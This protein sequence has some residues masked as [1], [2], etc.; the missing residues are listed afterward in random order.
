MA[1]LAFCGLGR[2]G[3]PMASRLVAAGHDLVVWNRSP[4]RAAELVEA[5]AR[6]AASPAEA[7]SSADAVMTMLTTPEVVESVTVGGGDSLA[8]GLRPGATLIEMS[9]IGPAA[10]RR[11]ADRLPDGVDM[12]DA[13]VLGSV[14]Q[15]TDGSLKVF[16]GG[17]EAAFER[18]RP[19][20]AVLG[21]PTRHGSLG[22]GAAMKLVANS[23][24]GAAMSAL[25][26]ALALADRLGLD[27]TLVLDTLA[28]SPLG[29]TVK[30]K[31]SKI[32][33][34]EY[35]PNFALA[36]AAKDMRL[37]DE[38]ARDAGLDARLVIAAR[39]HFDDANRAGLGELDYSAVIAQL[40]GRAE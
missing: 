40:R 8:A 18:W 14:P 10:V 28:E 12:L 9:T 33:S 26:E 36:L 15:A 23:T 35:E 7:A 11:L 1:T 16:V 5:G 31:R 3:H 39:A 27:Q 22:S 24:L 32:E 20:L 2:M 4:E 25:G 13:P 34:G 29:A 38:A 19:V 37:V 17:S 30:S 6:Q 21:R